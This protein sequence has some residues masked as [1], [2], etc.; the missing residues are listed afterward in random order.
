VPSGL[1]LDFGK[2]HYAFRTIS[3]LPWGIHKSK[4]KYDEHQ[5]G[6]GRSHLGAPARRREKERQKAIRQ[7]VTKGVNKKGGDGK[8]G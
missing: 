7:E 6:H 3:T 1:E 2:G 4:H 5:W 8:N